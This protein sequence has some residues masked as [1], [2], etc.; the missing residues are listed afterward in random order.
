MLKRKQLNKPLKVPVNSK[1]EVE[2][3][4]PKGA[5]LTPKNGAGKGRSNNTKGACGE[6]LAKQDMAAEG[7]DDIVAVQ[8][9][10]GHGVDLIGRNSQT[11]E[12][13][14][15]EVKTTEGTQAPALKGDQ[16]N[17]GA[18]FTNSRIDRA[19]RGVG[20]YGKVPEARKNAEK[21]KEWIEDANDK[22]SYEKREVFI[23]DI[24]K[25]CAKHPGRPSRSKPWIAK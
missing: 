11:G 20:N 25:G 8:N 19:A 10:S 17:G 12:V 15:W 22:V 6:Q 3:E 16:R 18:D 23:D 5:E 9:N 14:I 21:V 24:S 7:F 2:A 1:R 4:L 13:K